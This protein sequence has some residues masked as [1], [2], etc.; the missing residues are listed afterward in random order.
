ME[1]ITRLGAVHATCC[2]AHLDHDNGCCRA[3]RNDAHAAVLDSWLDSHFESFL[4]TVSRRLK[5]DGL[6]V[7]ETPFMRLQSACSATPPQTVRLS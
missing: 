2:R 7:G 1:S 4:R 6:C 3:L 5:A